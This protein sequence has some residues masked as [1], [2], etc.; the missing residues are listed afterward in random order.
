MEADIKE[1][2]RLPP[3]TVAKGKVAPDRL[4]Y[5]CGGFY[6]VLICYYSKI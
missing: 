3:K 2:L 5:F 1:I 6:T 4:G